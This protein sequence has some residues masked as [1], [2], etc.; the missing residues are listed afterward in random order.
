VEISSAI[1]HRYLVKVYRALSIC[2]Y[3]VQVLVPNV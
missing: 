2:I 1:S 3:A